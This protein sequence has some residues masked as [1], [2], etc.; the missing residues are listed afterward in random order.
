[1]TAIIALLIIALM[2]SAWTLLFLYVKKQHTSGDFS[3][4]Q[5]NDAVQQPVRNNASPATNLF[6]KSDSILQTGTFASDANQGFHSSATHQPEVPQEELQHEAKYNYQYKR[7]TYLMTRAEHEF[8]DALIMAVNGEYYIFP[9]IHLS[10]IVDSKVIGQSWHGAFK[11]INQ[12]SVDFVLCDK[13]YL[14]P[15]LAIE[16]DDYTHQRPDRILRDQEVERVLREAEL[17][18]LRI[19][20]SGSF[21]SSEIAQKISNAIGIYSIAQVL[22]PA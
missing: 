13:K 18:L 4:S 17:P 16:L 6:G 10:D 11:H 19:K 2:V 12:K 1:M 8:F 20:N 22:T 21:D 9:Q 5:K 14:S 15:I 3:K 7:K